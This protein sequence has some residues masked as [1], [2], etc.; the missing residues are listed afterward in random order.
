[1]PQLGG[2]RLC[3]C[4]AVAH[5]LRVG[6][7]PMPPEPTLRSVSIGSSSLV[8]QTL[9]LSSVARWPVWITSGDASSVTCVAGTMPEDEKGGWVN[10]LTFEQLWLP[11]GLA[12]PKS[13]AALGAV[14]KNGV[15]R[16][17]FPTTA[18]TVGSDGGRRLWYN[19]GVNS[20]PLA[21][22]WLT[23]GDIPIDD[24]RLSAYTQLLPK[25]FGS[26]EAEVG[27]DEAVDLAIRR[28]VWKPVLP[29][30]S[31][32]DAFNTILEVM[33]SAPDA[34][35]EGFCYLI[36]P[37]SEEVALPEEA[38]LPGNRLRLFLSDVDAT[39]GKPLNLDDREGWKWT[40]AE[41]DL[42]MFETESGRESDF[43]P[44]VYKPLFL[45]E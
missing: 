20:L 29:L 40:H 41:C 8:T 36:V 19:R 13:R 4:F 35:G 18:T 23:F 6:T 26:K 33:A 21:K 44:E 43:M 45:S 30:I 32:A 5:G 34:L 1:M 42:S 9:P 25:T 28:S 12:M 10:P 39:D 38:I 27:S 7:L 14:L 24:L 37:L 22:T 17:L 15:P 16:F 3:F 31:V 11:Q 2:L